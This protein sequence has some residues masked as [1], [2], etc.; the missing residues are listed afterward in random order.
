MLEA[1]GFSCGAA[2]IDGDFGGGTEQAVKAFQT[3]Y[4]LTPDGVVGK[5]TWPVLVKAPNKPEDAALKTELSALY[6]SADAFRTRVKNALDTFD[7][8]KA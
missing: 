6:A 1:T 5:K 2:G 3:E 7:K 4:R 8:S